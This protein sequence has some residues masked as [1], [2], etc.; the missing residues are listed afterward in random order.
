VA[1]LRSAVDA[2][3]QL[4][5]VANWLAAA[6]LEH[7]DTRRA[8]RQ[9]KLDCQQ[10]VGGFGRSVV[11]DF[12]LE[13]QRHAV[14][15]GRHCGVV[16]SHFDAQVERVGDRRRLRHRVVDARQRC[17]R[18]TLATN[19]VLLRHLGGEANQVDATGGTVLHIDRKATQKGSVN[20]NN[21]NK[22][23]KK[24]KK[25]K[26]AAKKKPHQLTCSEQCRLVPDRS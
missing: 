12:D 5:D 4:I 3:D 9:H 6:R 25:T 11:D 22:N 10:R 7:A 24:K 14:V 13:E 16:G 17:C 26:E 15:A 23:K 18:L 1:E 8:A 2:A 20:N 19:A 21:K